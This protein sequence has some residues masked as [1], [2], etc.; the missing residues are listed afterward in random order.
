MDAFYAKPHAKMGRK[1]KFGSFLVKSGNK[2]QNWTKL[3]KTFL[4]GTKVDI[5]GKNRKKG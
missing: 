1:R 2:G 4:N 3:P 5:T